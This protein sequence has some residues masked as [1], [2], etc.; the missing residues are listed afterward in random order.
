MKT[1]QEI[2]D[3]LK[4]DYEDACNEYVYLF[5]KK[6]DMEFQGWIGDIVGGTAYC[7]DL[8]FN[9]LDIVWDVNTNQEAGKITDWYF[10]AMDSVEDSVNYYTYTKINQDETV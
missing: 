7:S 9:F 10:S 1:R 8:C 6:Q 5:C 3:A 4:E 2:I